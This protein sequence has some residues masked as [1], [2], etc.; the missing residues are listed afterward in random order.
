[1]PL[2]HRRGHERTIARPP[3]LPDPN[4]ERAICGPS[5]ARYTHGVGRPDDETAEQIHDALVHLFDYASLQDHPLAGTLQI[6]E[7]GWDRGAALHRRLIE[8]IGQLRPPADTPPHSA[9]WRRHRCAVLRYVEERTVAEVGRTLGVSER[10]V[11]RDAHEVVVTIADMV[12]IADPPTSAPLAS[13]PT[14]ADVEDEAARLIPTA[15]TTATRPGEVVHS[16][17]ATLGP[18]AEVRTVHLAAR[19]APDLPRV[20]IE[21]SVLRQIILGEMLWLLELARPGGEVSIDVA[22]VDGGASVA[23]DLRTTTEPGRTD[24][25]SDR[26]HV[27]TRLAELH[28][29]TLAHRTAGGTR[30]VAL[31][32]PVL[33]V[34]TVLLVDDNPGMIQLIRRFLT[35]LPIDILEAPSAAAALRLARDVQPD[36]ITA[37]VMMPSADGWE[38]LQ[39]L[40]AHPRTRHIPV[41]V[42]SVVNEHDLARSL[43]AAGLIAK[44]VTRDA[45]IA[46]LAGLGLPVTDSVDPASLAGFASLPQP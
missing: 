19:L 24:A 44:P 17:L 34:P 7:R 33:R 45:L 20:A 16:V 5:A 15:G 3:R 2:G 4:G 10:Q 14:D 25:D 46:A 6:A 28:G 1:M 12:R 30:H 43:G 36:A 9:L 21:R 11:R 38:L 32:V 22:K 8:A 40:R 27:G 35:G 39:A 23:I 29:A 18:L 31:A 41:V 26:L 13:D 37:D 42:C